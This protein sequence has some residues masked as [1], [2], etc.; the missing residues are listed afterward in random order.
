MLPLPSTL[1]L[2]LALAAP[3]ACAAWKSEANIPKNGTIKSI[4]PTRLLYDISWNG[5][6]KA[7]ALDLTFGKKDKRYPNH[8]IVHGTGG[9]TGWARAL[10]PATVT[11]TGLL[12]PTNR[13]PVKFWGFEDERRETVSL[14]FNFNSHGVSGTSTTTDKSSK[15]AKTT[16]REF[17]YPGSLE[18]FS[19][20]MQVRSMP[21]AN[22]DKIVMP[23]HPVSRPY[24]ARVKVLGREKHLGRDCIKMDVALQ[25]IGSDMKLKTYKKLKNSTVW[26]SDD[27]WRVP[28]E[29]R[30]KVYVG[31]VRIT[32][33][34]H[35][36]L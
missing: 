6:I 21:L 22:G 10:Y 23:F 28:I 19:G 4:P 18:L 13:R 8:Y 17:N 9:S 32:L 14:F 11:Y 36:A 26:L 34:K 3:V 35:D 1:I 20:L 5:K 33:T 27:A 7:G 2:T 25:K 16:N 29:V 12:D 30:A 24:L 15:K 31:D